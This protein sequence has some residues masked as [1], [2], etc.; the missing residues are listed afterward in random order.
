MHT[1]VK[2]SY[3]LV[4]APSVKTQKNKKKKTPP[5]RTQTEK[6]PNPKAEKGCKVGKSGLF[7]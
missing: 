4:V 2:L 7:I 1:T 6:K 5:K 3:P